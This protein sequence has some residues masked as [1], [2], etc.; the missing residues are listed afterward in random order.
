MSLASTVDSRTLGQGYLFSVTGLGSLLRPGA[1][2]TA[3]LQ[4]EGKP[5]AGIVI[6]ES[7]LV[8]SAGKIWAYHQVADDQFTRV[9]IVPERSTSRGV[10]VTRGV[11]AGDRIV[12]VG[13]QVLLS[14]EQKSQI[15]ILEENEGK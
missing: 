13:A 10:L 14:E 9:E 5:A 8:R 15:K 4:I 11:S 2:I 12:T 7:A 6:P 3:Y 1:A